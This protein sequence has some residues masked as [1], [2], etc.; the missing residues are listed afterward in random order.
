MGEL[1]SDKLWQKVSRILP[2][3]KELPRK[4]MGK[5][6]GRKPI[7]DRKVFTG[8]VFILKNNLS[9]GSLP[10]EMGYGSG[11]TCWRRL[12]RWRDAG[13]LPEIL[14]AMSPRVGRRKWSERK[15]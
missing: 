7:D 5:K 13:I 11:I 15:G 6:R 1:V 2:E 3:E 9:W 12:K 4:T 14:E 10:I 8:I